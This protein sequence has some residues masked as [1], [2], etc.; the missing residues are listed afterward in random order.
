MGRRSVPSPQ[1]LLRQ[2]RPPTA[3]RPTCH[4]APARRLP[5]RPRPPGGTGRRLHPVGL[6]RRAGRRGRRGRRR[7][8]LGHG[9]R[10]GA[11]VR[12]G[13]PPRVVLVLDR[14]GRLRVGHAAQLPRRGDR[15]RRPPPGPGVGVGRDARDDD[16]GGQRREARRGRGRVRPQLRPP[17]PTGP[18]ADAAGRVGRPPG[19]GGRG[20]R[21]P[22]RGRPV[23][24]RRRRPSRRGRR[25]PGAGHGRHRRRRRGL[26]PPQRRAL[27]CRG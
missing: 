13:C 16:A 14:P 7:R 25:L 4:P 17:G 5:P 27:P 2:R 15:R 24:R 8:R 11:G 23:L 19:P 12:A 22:G 3:A 18:G 1:R 6:S 20:R 21:R 26:V 9:Q 10:P